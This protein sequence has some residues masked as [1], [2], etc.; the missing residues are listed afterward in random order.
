M[1]LFDIIGPVMIGP[2]SSHTAGAAR[3]GR[4]TRRLLGEPVIRAEIVLHGSFAKTWRGHGTDRAVI[5]GLLDMDVDDVRLRESLA[6]AEQEGMAFVFSTSHVK[7]AHPNTVLIHAY[8]AS[9]AQ[10]RV[11]GASIGGGRIR[12][13]RLDGLEVSFSGEVDTLVIRHRDLPGQV[14]G[15]TG[16]VANAGVN[17]AAMRMFRE[18]EGGNAVMVLELDAR[19]AAAVIDAIR[20]L[21][22]VHGVTFLERR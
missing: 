15:A 3:I 4:V 1:D 22:D 21:P 12:V 11:Q 2:S 5:G 17:I 7:D 16:L 13:E 10:V 6:I 14:A 18:T 9:G 19:P 8:G 20:A